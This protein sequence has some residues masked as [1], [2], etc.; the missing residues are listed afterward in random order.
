M[1]ALPEDV[2]PEIMSKLNQ[3]IAATGGASNPG[4]N[5]KPERAAYSSVYCVSCIASINTTRPLSAAL[6]PR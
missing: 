1:E 4:H 2:A 5:V 6:M 3:A